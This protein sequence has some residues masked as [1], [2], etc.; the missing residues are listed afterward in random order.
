MRGRKR[1]GRIFGIV[2]FFGGDLHFPFRGLLQRSKVDFR[3]SSQVSF[4]SLFLLFVIDEGL[5]ADDYWVGL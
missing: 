4:I 1:G 5:N 3:L 2:W